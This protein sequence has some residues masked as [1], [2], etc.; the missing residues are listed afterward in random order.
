MVIQNKIAMPLRVQPSVG[1][2]NYIGLTRPAF[3]SLNESGL[4]SS[5]AFL[6]SPLPGSRTDE[7]QVFDNTIIGKN[8]SAASVYY[9]WNNAWRSIS[10]GS[11]DVGNDAV[12]QP[13]LGVI[14]RKATNNSSP[15]WI[16]SPNW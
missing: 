9:Y 13:G 16:N 2:D 12:F 10:T 1:Q 4:I 3:M 6:A 5:G 14:L 11:S 8:K 7:L 15:S